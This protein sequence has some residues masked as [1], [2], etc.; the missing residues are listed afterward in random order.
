[1]REVEKEESKDLKEFAMNEILKAQK[2]NP[3]SANAK[4]LYVEK[5]AR[6]FLPKEDEEHGF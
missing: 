6:E 1:L 2:S 3:L 4:F 5:L